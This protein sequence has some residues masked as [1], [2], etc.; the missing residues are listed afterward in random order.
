MNNK[1]FTLKCTLETRTSKKSGND[2]DCLVL[3]LDPNYEKV[4][5]LD[6]SEIVLLQKNNVR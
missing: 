4:V 3:K 2:Y 6:K 1:E 5:F